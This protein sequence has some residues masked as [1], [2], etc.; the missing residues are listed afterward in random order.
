MAHLGQPLRSAIHITHCVPS[1]SSCGVA[2]ACDAKKNYRL[3]SVLH[4]ASC[5]VVFLFISH[6]RRRIALRAAWRLSFTPSSS[7]P[8]GVIAIEPTLRRASIHAACS[9]EIDR[10][11]GLPSASPA[12]RYLFSPIQD[13]G[14]VPTYSARRSTPGPRCSSVKFA[15]PPCAALIAAAFY[16]GQFYCSGRRRRR[17]LGADSG[18]PLCDYTRSPAEACAPLPGTIANGHGVI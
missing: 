14:A 16:F 12:R 9:L 3:T 17:P 18:P 1:F 13:A 8:P 11:P 7:E 5:R 15:W 10:D 2:Y 4:D 6:S